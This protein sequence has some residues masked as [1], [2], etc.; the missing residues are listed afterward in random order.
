MTGWSGSAA[1]ARR[2]N[3]WS[4]PPLSPSIQTIRR[5][6]RIRLATVQLEGESGLPREE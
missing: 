5:E 2:W 4:N 1:L 3:T 6:V